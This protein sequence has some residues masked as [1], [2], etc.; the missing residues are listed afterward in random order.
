MAE[1]NIRL[2]DVRARGAN[3]VNLS[4]NSKRVTLKQVAEPFRKFTFP[5]GPLK[6]QYD[7]IGLEY[8]A[9]DRPNDIALLEPVATKPRS[10]SF[11]AV[12]AEPKTGGQTGVQVQLGELG[13]MSREDI[14]LVFTYGI[15]V[16]PWKVRITQF[17]Y[18][19]V[20]RNLDGAITQAV[21]SIELTERPYRNPSLVSLS[22]IEYVPP[23]NTAPY[24]G[25]SGPSTTPS[26]PGGGGP[27]YEPPDVTP[28]EFGTRPYFDIRPE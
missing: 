4:P 20:R 14:D 15:F 1:V 17:N 7:D 10:L 18:E 19:S 2:N 22:A 9:I 5:I 3:V 24:T 12:I 6:V 23:L 28:G 25:P 27:T 8:V 11:N 13:L 26:D 21:A 16:F